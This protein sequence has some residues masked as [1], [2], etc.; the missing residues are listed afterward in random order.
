M[1]LIR[2]ISMPYRNNA[3]KATHVMALYL[4]MTGPRQRTKANPVGAVR[5]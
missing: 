5:L 4:A 1:T 3:L 2:G